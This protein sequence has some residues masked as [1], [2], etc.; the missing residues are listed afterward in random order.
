MRWGDNRLEQIRE[1]QARAAADRKRLIER[2]KGRT[3]P[4]QG[5]EPSE[6]IQ[7]CKPELRRF[8]NLN[9]D[10]AMAA[11]GR[12]RFMLL[13]ATLGQRCS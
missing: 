13:D 7:P 4:I 2:L 12:L 6:N 1:G 3:A 5:V 10:D 9:L 11:A 8:G